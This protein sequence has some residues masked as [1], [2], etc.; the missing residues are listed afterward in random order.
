MTISSIRRLP[1]WLGQGFQGSSWSLLT[2][3]S[4]RLALNITMRD[5]INNGCQQTDRRC[6]HSSRRKNNTDETETPTPSS[7]APEGES[8]VADQQ[9]SVEKEQTP[10]EIARQ[11]AE[12]WVAKGFTPRQAAWL[13]PDPDKARK[14][15][16]TRKEAGS[17]G[18]PDMVAEYVREVQDGFML[19]EG[20]SM[21]NLDE[22]IP[23]ILEPKCPEFDMMTSIREQQPDVSVIDA[24]RMVGLDI[25]ESIVEHE[26]QLLREEK[27]GVPHLSWTYRNVLTPATIGEEHPVN[28]KV[29]C[30]FRLKTLQEFHGLS[31]EAAEYIALICDKRYNPKTGMV[32]LVSDSCADRKGNTERIEQIIRDLVEEG[33]RVGQKQRAL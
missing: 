25:P 3:I 2:G 17:Y 7:S 6:V 4:D 13:S 11:R 9:T 10:G 5:C 29:K 27:E 8:E 14:P 30:E 24:A 32:T 28:K 1:H 23:E 22:A 19:P 15:R 12:A 18:R 31:D 33:K 20:V 26:E 21:Y 16:L